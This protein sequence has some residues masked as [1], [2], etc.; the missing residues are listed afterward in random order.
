MRFVPVWAL[1]VW[2]ALVSPTGGQEIAVPPDFRLVAQYGPGLTGL[3]PW[4]VTIDADGSAVQETYGGDSS[5]KASRAVTL[6][7]DDVVR[8]ARRVADSRFFELAGSYA[9]AGTHPTL[10]LRVTRNEASHEVVVYMPPQLQPSDEVRRFLLV[11]DEL[12][13]TVPSPNPQQR[14]P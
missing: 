6:S 12:L 11:W 7:R 10:N 14:A 13:R 2:L 1:L 3:K 9:A 5:Q 4:T 8:L